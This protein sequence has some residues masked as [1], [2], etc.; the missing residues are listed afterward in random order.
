MSEDEK[1]ENH[2]RLVN[3]ASE[4]NKLSLEVELPPDGELEVKYTYLNEQ[5]ETYKTKVART[6]GKNPVK[7]RKQLQI[8]Q[9][10]VRLA[11]ILSLIVYFLV[12]IVGIE[13][14]P[15]YFFSDEAIQS[16]HAAD[17]I[18]DQF[19]SPYGEL[20]P[21]FFMNG[22]QYN[23]SVSVYAQVLPVFMLGKAIWITRGTAVLFSLLAALGVG[24]TI[25]Y[26]FDKKL[27][28][29]AILL[30]SLMPAWF[31]HSRTAFETSLSV[32]FYACF[33]SFYM[34]YRLKNP[35]F[36][37]G[38]VIF[39]ALAFYSYNPMRVIVGIT[40]LGL[41]FSDLQYHWQQ[42]KTFLKAFGLGLLC[43][44]PLLRFSLNYPGE[45]LRH[46]EILGS[47][48]VQNISKWEKIVT[49]LQE[50]IKGL[51][52]FYWF[53]PNQVD[54][55]RHLMKGYGHLWQPAMPF[56]FVG[57]FWC[58]KY[59]KQSF[60]R[61]VI[62]AMLAAPVGAAIVN[63][64]ITRALVMVIPATLLTTIGLKTSWDWFV[65]KIQHRGNWLLKMLPAAG[66]SIFAFLSL[67]NVQMLV[68]A[69]KN[70]PTWFTNYGLYGMQYGA[71][72]VFGTIE[73]SLT[74]DPNQKFYLTSTW[75]NGADVL[76]RYFFDDPVPFEMGS[77]DGFINEYKPLDE[78]M[79]FIMVPDEMEKMFASKKFTN[80]RT[81]NMILY[82]NGAPG[83]YFVQLSYVDNI[84][85]IFASEQEARRALKQGKVAL[86]DGKEV[87]VAYSTLDMG[88]IIHVFDGDRT[89]LA[90]TFE[91][92]PM[93]IVVTFSEPRPVEKIK[94]RVGGDATRIDVRIWVGGS[95]EPLSF[96]Q[97]LDS[98]ADPR[99]TEIDLQK[100]LLVKTLE[101][102]V[103]NLNN[104]EPAHVHLWELQFLPDQP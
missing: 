102:R 46:L 29:L 88:E 76:A 85:E 48:W 50:Y 63:L 65:K 103:K 6:R 56:I 66:I 101:V 16:V 87:Q 78:D 35:K 42:R 31:L 41:F 94:L 62:I 21:T 96:M 54:L 33:L 92:N 72:Q 20:L 1:K 82:P 47:Y 100:E 7:N 11:F 37:Y 9:S 44:I 75:T 99:W 97:E 34:L 83:F 59:F 4:G 64:G 8:L 14:F 38:A 32:S 68:D 71:R 52:P 79:I 51:N 89:T 12:R 67:L 5:G 30:L 55:D 2:P 22:G 73:A 23:L 49:F 28:W 10:P 70:G 43:L 81:G 24:L 26:A 61:L 91:A 19:H 57:I 90:R 53:I 98:E 45:S 93:K 74:L 95:E 17:L 25:Q 77:I 80:V 15:I 40:L 84:R 39:S 104:E 18:R 36:L 58:I 86:Q 69:L 13:D 3:Q 27:G 60:A